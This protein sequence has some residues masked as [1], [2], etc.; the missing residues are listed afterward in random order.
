ML[1]LMKPSIKTP[2]VSVTQ[3]IRAR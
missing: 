3:C 1:F 2:V